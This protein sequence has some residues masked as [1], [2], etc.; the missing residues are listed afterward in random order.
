[1]PR[2]SQQLEEGTVNTPTTSKGSPLRTG[3][4]KHPAFALQRKAGLQ[5]SDAENVSR[6]Q[7]DSGVKPGSSC[8]SSSPTLGLSRKTPCGE[9][10]SPFNKRFFEPRA[11]LLSQ[12]PEKASDHSHKAPLRFAK[13]PGLWSPESGGDVPE[14]RRPLPEA[15]QKPNV[16]S[17]E[18]CSCS[19]LVPSGN[20]STTRPTVRA[21]L[22]AP[23][24][25]TLRARRG[26]ALAILRGHQGQS[27]GKEGWARGPSGGSSA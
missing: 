18:R 3:K 2:H 27:E 9:D 1:M 13:D 5:D 19:W 4:C 21:R 25:S 11:P 26:G 7:R 16:P 22:G 12:R 8:P 17:G 24:S 6:Q 20:T 10:S 15:T 23:T 14:S